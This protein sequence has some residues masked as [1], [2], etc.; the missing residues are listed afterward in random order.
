MRLALAVPKSRLEARIVISDPDDSAALWIDSDRDQIPVAGK[1]ISPGQVPKSGSARDHLGGCQPLSNLATM[2]SVG[3][4][5]LLNAGAPPI[6]RGTS[7]LDKN[8]FT[9][10]RPAVVQSRLAELESRAAQLGEEMGVLKQVQIE[11]AQIRS[12][13][14]LQGVNL[15]IPPPELQVRVSGAYDMN[16]FRL[17]HDLGVSVE[18][19]L[20]LVN[21][22]FDDFQRIFDFGC[23]CG[24]VVIPLSLRLAHPERLYGADIDPEAIQWCKSHI[25]GV[26]GFEVNPH[27]PPAPFEDESFDLVYGI[28]VFTHL[29]EEMQFSWM[30][31]LVRVCTK[32]AYLVLTFHGE[33]HHGLVQ[34]PLADEL[35]EKGFVYSGQE[36]GTTEGLPDFY[37]TSFHTHDY[38]RERWGEYF[39][40]L[41]IRK[42]A[43]GTQDAVLLRKR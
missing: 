34:G 9:Q 28:S 31:D 1:G 7:I 19:M 35:N 27:E 18:S 38:V 4:L 22:G 26:G 23:G 39:E 2:H 42:D 5:R 3:G 20:G 24:R 17:G 15:T 8:G 11:V 41:E 6:C 32:D 12:L 33:R 13:L 43:V 14:E 21:K 37:Q 16:F 40:V 10:S 25:H 36:K 29:P 30:Q